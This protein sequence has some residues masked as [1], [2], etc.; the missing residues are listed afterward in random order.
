MVI[1]QRWDEDWDPEALHVPTFSTSSG[2]P[3]ISLPDTLDASASVLKAGS[4]NTQNPHDP[5]NNF[6]E[7]EI[8]SAAKAEL[9]TTE[10]R[11]GCAQPGSLHIHIR[12]HAVLN[13]RC[14]CRDLANSNSSRDHCNGSVGNPVATVGHLNHGLGCWPVCLA[15]ICCISLVLVTVSDRCVPQSKGNRNNQWDLL[16]SSA[17]NL[18]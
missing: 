11:T 15:Y 10:Q 5:S 18:G 7:K 4:R 17:S 3:G 6:R 8:A 2:A 16:T 13:L 1:D 14:S 9:M 12:S